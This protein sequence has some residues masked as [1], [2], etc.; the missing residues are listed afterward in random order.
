MGCKSG[1]IKIPV[2]LVIDMQNLGVSAFAAILVGS[3]IHVPD[4]LLF[5]DMRLNP[6][7]YSTDDLRRLRKT[8][9]NLTM[10]MGYQNGVVTTYPVY[11][12]PG[13]E[14]PAVLIETGRAS[15]SYW[16]SNSPRDIRFSRID[17]SLIYPYTLMS[18]YEDIS[19]DFRRLHYTL[20]T[21]FK[22]NNSLKAAFEPIIRAEK[23]N[24]EQHLSNTSALY[25]YM[26]TNNICVASRHRTG[27]V[28]VASEDRTGGVTVESLLV[29]GSFEHTNQ[30]TRHV[31]NLVMQQKSLRPAGSSYTTSM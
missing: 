15:A 1:N 3:T 11:F 20:P 21:Y 2:K 25:N 28:T 6:D 18:P 10:Q 5:H 31:T 27:G 7:L 9:P 16:E 26:I 24:L 22:D 13:T 12:E 30:A 4:Y 8:H 17:E 29:P 23:E 14:K 19:S